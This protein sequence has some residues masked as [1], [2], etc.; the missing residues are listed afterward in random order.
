MEVLTMLCSRGW[1]EGKP[2]DDTVSL[3]M[4]EYSRDAG[5]TG[6]SSGSRAPGSSV[7]TPGIA[8]RRGLRRMNS[9]TAIEKA[10][11]PRTAKKVECFQVVQ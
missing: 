7:Y 11:A 5:S 2:G 8:L 10:S 9:T 6:G 4:G 3:V 1:V